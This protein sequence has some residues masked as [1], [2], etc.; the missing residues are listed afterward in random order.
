[1]EQQCASPDIQS[2][3]TN[4]NVPHEPEL[5]PASSATRGGRRSNNQQQITSQE[6]SS[7]GEPA[8]TSSQEI[9]P[10]KNRRLGASVDPSLM[11]PSCSPEN[12]EKKV[13]TDV[14]YA[15]K[16]EPE[17]QQRI[18]VLIGTAV[19]RFSGVLEILLILVFG[20]ILYLVDIGSDIWA[21]VV[22]FQE[23]DQIWGSLTISFVLL[24]AVSWAAVSWSWWYYDRDK[25]RHPT[26]RRVRMLLAALLLDPLVRYD[27]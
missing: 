11:P 17:Q 2:D 13:T 6:D 22:Y 1:M 3:R 24:S 20:I 19:D 15:S 16:E 5:E 9:S 14:T 25:D 26:Y 12:P 4:E 23:G 27:A 7:K 21:A 8:A 10:P 18:K